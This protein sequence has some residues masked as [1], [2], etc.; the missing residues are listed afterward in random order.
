MCG[1]ELKN[2]FPVLSFVFLCGFYLCSLCGSIELYFT[3]M[4]T[5][6]NNKGTKHFS[7][8]RQSNKHKNLINI[9][10]NYVNAMKLID[11]NFKWYIF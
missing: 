10:G 3:T 2:D 8:I 9:S 4:D 6:A 11:C 7:S 1:N 5:K